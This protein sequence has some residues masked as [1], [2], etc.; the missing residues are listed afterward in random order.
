MWKIVRG[1]KWEFQRSRTW[2][3]LWGRNGS[4]LMGEIR[5]KWDRLGGQRKKELW[6]WITNSKDH[7]KNQMKA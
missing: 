7:F 1:N 2:K 6:G 5:V 4:L 3:I